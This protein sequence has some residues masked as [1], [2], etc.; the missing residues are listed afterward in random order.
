M[1]VNLSKELSFGSVDDGEMS[2]AV[3]YL[4]LSYVLTGS[5]G[6]R[7]ARSLLIFMEN[8][9]RQSWAAKSCMKR[10]IFLNLLISSVNTPLKRM[11]MKSYSN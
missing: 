6:L 4:S 9:R 1:E 10:G 2:Y 11:T 7:I 3:I 5:I 8:W